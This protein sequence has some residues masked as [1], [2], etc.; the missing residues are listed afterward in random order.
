MLAAGDFEEMRVILDYYTNLAALL[1]PRTQAYFGHPG[2]WTT[3]THML[4]GAYT[5]SDYGCSRAPDY[6][7]QYE[8]S[9]YLHVDQGGDSGTGEWS[10]MALDFYAATGDAR[11]LPL[12]FGAADYFM[13]HFNTSSATGRAVIFPA[14]VLE[15]WWC[16]WDTA[17]RAW[18]NCCEDDSPTISGMMTL[19]EK[20]RA[21]PPAL[22]TPAQRAAWDSFAA[23]RMP[24]LPLEPDGTIA[25]ARVLSTGTHNGEGPTLYIAH[26]HR[27]F[28]RAR[29]VAGGRN[30]SVGIATFLA[31]PFRDSNSG[32]AYAINAAALLGLADVAA[33][34]LAQRANTPPAAGYRFPAYAPHL[35]AFVC[36]R[37]CR[38]RLCRACFL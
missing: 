7:V 4:F 16:E 26:P 9:G 35:R 29:E 13:H 21:L 23:L 10:L 31:S 33:A 25:P 30:A 37:G 22:T 1:A 38:L 36:A 11:Y 12:A 20:L 5:P 15:S 19:F 18:S 17:A 8:A 34:Q 28:T 27:V 32:W 24:D 14:Q 6:P 3:E 2:V